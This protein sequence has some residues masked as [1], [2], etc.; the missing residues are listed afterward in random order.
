MPLVKDFY[1]VLLRA[2]S[3]P[4]VSTLIYAYNISR[5]PPALMECLCLSACAWHGIY[6]ARIKSRRGCEERNPEGQG[7][8]VVLGAP[9]G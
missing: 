4:L 2:L 5:L 9:W 1:A 6:V 3:F 7:N 8:D